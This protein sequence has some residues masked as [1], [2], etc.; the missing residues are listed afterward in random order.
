MVTVA[1]M[2]Q[3]VADSIDHNVATLDGNCSL[4]DSV[5]SRVLTTMWPHYMV[6]VACMTQWVADSVDHNV[7]TLDGNCSLHD[8]VGSREC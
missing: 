4:Y 1:C 5:G 7:P 2:T 3:W 8:S 6:T